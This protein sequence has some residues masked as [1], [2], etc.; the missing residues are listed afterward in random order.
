MPDKWA[1]WLR[2]PC[3]LRGHQHFRVGHNISRAPQK[4]GWATSSLPLGGPQRFTLEDKIR[5]ARQVG[6]LA[7]S[8][9][10]TEGS[11]TL[12]SGGQNQKWPTVGRIGYVTPAGWGGPN[13]SERFRARDKINSGSQKWKQLIFW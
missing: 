7:T 6:R 5:S 11:P 9:L 2:H 3:H 13:A 4:G 1:D 8:P 12:Q 10:P